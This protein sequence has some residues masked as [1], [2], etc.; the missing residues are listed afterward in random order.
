MQN[1]LEQTVWQLSSY[2]NGNGDIVTAWGEAPA[3]FQFAAG[4]VTG[5][6]GCNRF[7][8]AYTVA[9][10][11]LA[12]APGGSTLMA[13]FPEALVQQ[14]SAIFVGMATVND[15]ELNADELQLLNSDGDVVFTLTPQVSAALT[16]T[17]WTLT[18]YNN[19]RGGLVSPLLDTTLTATFDEADG[20]VGSAGCNTYRANFEHADH[21][22][23][24]G[25][26]ASTRRLCSAPD[27]TMQQEQ[28][29]LRLLAE[30]STY[31]IDGN[32]LT[33]KDAAGTVLAKFAT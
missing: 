5:T 6:T 11:E 14:E 8:S 17:A 9:D 29:F 30:V 32:Q 28:V 25:A 27:G 16:N 12:I 4:Q 24:I 7:F 2:R 10:G 15:Y 33:L 26:A 20:L 13:C 21:T 3:T 18:A 22:L 19:G 1:P 31:D 23:Q